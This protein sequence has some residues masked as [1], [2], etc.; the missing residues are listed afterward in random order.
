VEEGGE[1]G[2]EEFVD[3]LDEVADGGCDGH[4]WSE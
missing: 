2:L 3:G 1:E 4:G